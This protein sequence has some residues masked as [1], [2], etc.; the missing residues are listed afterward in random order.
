MPDKKMYARHSRSYDLILPFAIL[1]WLKIQNS[2]WWASHLLHD[3]SFPR[4]SLSLSLVKEKGKWRERDWGALTDTRRLVVDFWILVCRAKTIKKSC[5]SPTFCLCQ[6][7]TLDF[8]FVR[9]TASPIFFLLFPHPMTSI[10][11]P[12][13]K[14]ECQMSKLNVQ[15]VS[16]NKMLWRA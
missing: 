9:V 3:P 6:F 15:K 5:S 4:L 10:M 13:F 12:C 7:E 1:Q 11:S 2:R 8:P 16:R 14:F